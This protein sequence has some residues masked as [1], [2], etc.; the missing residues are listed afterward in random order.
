MIFSCSSFNELL[1]S[2]MHHHMCN[3]QQRSVVNRFKIFQIM[4][5]IIRRFHE[6]IFWTLFICLLSLSLFDQL[7]L[8]PN[9]DQPQSTVATLV[10]YTVLF[11]IK[12]LKQIYFCRSR[13]DIS[14]RRTH[15]ESN[16]K[17][18]ACTT[19]IG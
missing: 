1:T 7:P 19:R 4:N 5:V 11:K 3:V 18:S 15:F 8:S 6:L 12:T 14:K 16:W 10:L 13:A 2:K 9:V 17:F